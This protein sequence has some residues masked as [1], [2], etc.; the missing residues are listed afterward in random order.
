[1]LLGFKTGEIIAKV[2]DFKLIIKQMTLDAELLAQGVIS[3]SPLE[4]LKNGSDGLQLNIIK[5]KVID[6]ANPA[7]PPVEVTKI[8]TSEQLA[9]EC[10]NLQILP[11]GSI[12]YDPYGV[13][14][15]CFAAGTLVHTKEGLK[16]IEEIRV[17]DWVLSYPDN[18]KTPERLRQEH[19]YTYRRVTQTFV[20]E[21]R[22]LSKLIVLNLVTGNKETFLVTANHPIFCEDRGGWVP[23]SEI[24]AGDITVQHRIGKKHYTDTYRYASHLPLT[25]SDD[26]FFT[27][28][29]V[30]NL[31]LPP[32]QPIAQLDVLPSGRW[33]TR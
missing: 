5:D 23:L 24:E 18:Q 12:K 20:T 9:Q 17:G 3:K 32:S 1:M 33:S 31:P 10:G 26:C 27:Q 29:Q 16:P 19:E 6:P 15:V 14:P 8:L 4:F 21:D 28:L 7:A 25:N 2:S 30:R 11:D 13:T 22:P